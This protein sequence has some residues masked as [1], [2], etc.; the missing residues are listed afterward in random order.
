MIA[1]LQPIIGP[2]IMTH[3][4]FAKKSC[5]VTTKLSDKTRNYNLSEIAAAK[6]AHGSQAIC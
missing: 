1:D 5:T 3:G 6:C 4:G 2:Q